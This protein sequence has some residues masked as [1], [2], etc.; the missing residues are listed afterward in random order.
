LVSGSTQVPLQ[1]TAP[2]GQPPPEQRPAL[3][4]WPLGH[5]SPQPPQLAPSVAST[6]QLLPHSAEPAGQVQI[7]ACAS[8]VV[9]PPQ[10]MASAPHA[11]PAE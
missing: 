2:L 4:V 1:S 6:A 5:T 3:Q 8:H 11:F 7:A 9:P 10:I